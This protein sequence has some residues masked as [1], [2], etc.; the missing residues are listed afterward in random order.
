MTCPLSLALSKEISSRDSRPLT[1]TR[2]EQ[3]RELTRQQA[4]LNPEVC[5]HAVVTYYDPRNDDMFVQDPTAGTWVDIAGTPKLDL[6]VGDWVE[7]RGM[8]Q[9][10]DFAPEV[11]KPRVRVLGRASLPIAP[12]VSFSQ[13]N[14]T[15]TNSRRV[16]VEGT[17]LDAT[18]QGEQLRLTLEVDGGTVN[19]PIA[20]APGP[21]PAN[22]VDAKVRIQ[23]VC[24]ASSNK[25]NQLI[26]VRVCLPSLGDLQMIEEGPGDPFAGPIHSISSILCFVPKKEAGRVKVR[27]V[28]TYRQVGR[29]LFIQDGNDGLFVE[30]KQRAP[31]EVGD[32]V[33]VAG[34]P[35]VSQGLSPILKHAVFRDLGGRVTVSP[36][37]ITALQVLQGEHDSELVRIKGRLLRVVDF[38]GERLLTL[39]ADSVIFEA[40]L[41]SHGHTPGL[42]PPETDS[43][44]ELTGVCSIQLNEQGDPV[45]FL[46]TLRSAQDIAVLRTPSWWTFTLMLRMVAM[47]AALV[48]AST[49]WAMLLKR[50][51]AEKT[52][53]IRDSLQREAAAR[54]RYQELFENANDMVFTCD[55]EG[56][57]SSLNK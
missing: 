17:V 29:G 39:D 36:R 47:L 21:I 5:F 45:G 1:L 50:Q 38:H 2:I 41:R 54:E 4:A 55:L 33:E 44:L 28:V 57:F 18:K 25:K 13:L 22:L 7:L 46:I 51:V 16:Q 15:S 37:L 27:G 31:L 43:L 14:M 24:G 11:G 52:E 23:G 19:V 34:F 48:I 6:K 8:G 56:R 10:P 20:F 26:A 49:L 12:I 35:S 40:D 30:S 32:Y 3:L 9:W 42:P 53:S